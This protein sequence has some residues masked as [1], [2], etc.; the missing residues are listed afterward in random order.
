VRQDGRPQAGLIL[1]RYD[2]ARKGLPGKEEDV[3]PRILARRRRDASGADRRAPHLPLARLSI[4]QTTTPG[5]SLPQALAAYERAG[6]AGIGVHLQKIEMCGRERAVELLHQSP[7]RVTSLGWAGGFTGDHDQTFHD[8]VE[9]AI[10][11]VLLASAIGAEAVHVLSGTAGG[12]IRSHA[13]RLLIDGLQ[14]LTDVAQREN[15][16]LAVQPMHRIFE[17]EWS[18][19]GGIDQT[20]EVLS[21]FSSEQV[22]LA[23][24]TYHFWQ[25]DRLVDRLH[26]LVP[27]IASVQLSDWR[28]PPRCD[29]DRLLPGDGVIPLRKIV[30]EI[31]RCGYRGCYEMEVWSR[32]LWKRNPHGL[33]DQALERY[34]EL[35]VAVPA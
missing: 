30:G 31:E 17:R 4:H 13:R 22:G 19:L 33:I 15:V 18:F 8:A 26:E 28:E 1:G 11:V 14:E 9:E 12:H 2:P 25:E 6:A 16:R 23:F 27:W 21:R 5:W 10:D 29:N 7:L 32:D 34:L 24:G 35:P 20:L 3:I